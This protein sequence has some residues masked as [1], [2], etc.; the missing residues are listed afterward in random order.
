MKL[1]GPLLYQIQALAPKHHGVF[2]V[3]DLMNLLLAKHPVELQ[4]KLKPLLKTGVLNRF[5]RGFYVTKEFDLEWLSQKIS[6][7]SAIS[8]GSVLAREMLIGSIPQKSVTAVKIGRSRVYES[9]LGRIVHLGLAQS[10]WFGYAIQK[11]GLRIASK[12]KAFLDTLYF[13]QSGHRLS[14]NIFSDVQTDKLD[15]KIVNSYLKKYKNP[16]FRKFVEGILDGKHSI[17]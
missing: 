7:S 12:E 14:F 5:C 4:Q 8:L 17:R 6:P 16:R 10:L 13:Y 11:G 9:E 2:T 3:H 1:E 15:R